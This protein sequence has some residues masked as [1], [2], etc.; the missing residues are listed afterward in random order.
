MII[1]FR[2][3]FILF[4]TNLGLIIHRTENKYEFILNFLNIKNLV[5]AQKKNIIL[6]KRNV[7]LKKTI[8][9]LA[10]IYIS[11]SVFAQI[12]SR[13]K[14]IKKY[15]KIAIQEMERAGVPASIKL[16]Q[17]ILESNA[18][19]STLARK[20]NNHFGMKC[21]S[22]WQGDTYYLEDDD[23]DETGRLIKSC[24]RVYKKENESYIAHS[25]FLRDP[26]KRYRYGDLFKL[27][28]RDYKAWARGLKAAGYATS[29]TYAE[30][31]IGI[32]ESYK[33]YQYDQEAAPEIDLPDDN[34]YPDDIDDGEIAA[35]GLDDSGFL[36][37]ND[38][39]MILAEKNDTP[40]EIANRTG[41]KTKC[42]LKYNDKLTKPTQYIAANERVY[43]QKKRNG[44]RGKKKYHQ[45]REGETIYQIS[46]LYG[47]KVEK[48]KKRNRI[49]KG[50]E[51]L[52][53][54]LIKL[55][56]WKVSKNKQPRTIRS[57]GTPKKKV[58]DPDLP[59]N[60]TETNPATPT[61]D[62]Q[63][64]I[65]SEEVEFETGDEI[66]PEETFN[67]FDEEL[68]QAQPVYHQVV[69]GDT[70]YK[71][72]KYYGTS[73]EDIRLLNQMRSNILSVGKTLRVK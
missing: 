59:N 39:K 1:N 29:P 55:R 68:P 43:L 52:A 47:V 23:Y 12:N 6:V 54:T 28:P 24:F 37:L 33:L 30:K 38:V 48:L 72:S 4:A 71:L 49:A 67:P 34:R 26:R 35:E 66:D 69:K 65:E 8:L 57:F 50:H 63:N 58:V 44:Y 5:L 21:G 11:G 51:P 53:G 22:Q 27:N 15:K 2:R 25:E 14:Y 7:M 3:K 73:V 9:L 10:L 20:A 46:Q 41:V 18:G 36:Y 64:P 42:L 31:L 45:V 40:L 60:N 32:I 56:G 70:L 61:V 13:E 16:A 19:Q 17:G 62:T